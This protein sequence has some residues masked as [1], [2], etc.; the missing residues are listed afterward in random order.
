M[1]KFG[2]NT[3][4]PAI[5]FNKLYMKNIRCFKGNHEIDLGNGNGEP[6]QWTVILGNNN[7]GKTTILRIIASLE[8]KVETTLKN[9]KRKSYIG[10]KHI[11]FE[12]YVSFNEDFFFAGSQL[13]LEFNC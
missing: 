4:Q 5:Y 10:N 8:L 13:K 2:Q 7:V 1:K 6:S 9:E 11:S 12:K 3:D